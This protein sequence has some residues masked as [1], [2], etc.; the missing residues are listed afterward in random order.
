MVAQVFNPM[1]ASAYFGNLLQYLSLP[2]LIISNIKSIAFG[3]IISVV[4]MAQGLAVDRSSTEV[5]IAG[6]KAVGASFGWCILVD[7]ILSAV[8]YLLL[9]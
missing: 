3:V 9:V 4:A 8:Y 1:S 5:P 6:L 7:I 2:D